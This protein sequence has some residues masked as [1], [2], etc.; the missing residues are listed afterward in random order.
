[1]PWDQALDIILQAKGLDMR[2]NGNVIWIAP[3][4]EIATREKLELESTQ[5]DRR[6]RAAARRRASSSTT[7]RAKADASISSRTR[8]RPFCRSAAALIVDERTQQAVRHGRAEPPRRP[9]QA[10]RGDRHSGAAGVDRGANRRS[11]RHLQQQPRRPTWPTMISRAPA[12][13]LRGIT[14]RDTVFGGGLADTAFTTGQ[15][16]TPDSELLH[17]YRPA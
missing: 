4:D 16:A 13:A 11:R 14:A 17:Q 2:K 15:I 8:I 6:P 3:R 5:S 1:M 10:H 12:T 9:A 7:I